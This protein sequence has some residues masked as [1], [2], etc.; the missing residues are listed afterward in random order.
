[1]I[2]HR[3]QCFHTV[4][5][6]PFSWLHIGPQPLELAY[7]F[8]YRF[9]YRSVYRLVYRFVYH[10]GTLQSPVLKVVATLFNFSLQ[11]EYF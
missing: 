3:L 4:K 11:H 5:I 6:F 7:R 9:V 1:M 2:S 10:T 8:M